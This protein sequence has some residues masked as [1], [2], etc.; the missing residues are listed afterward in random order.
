[1]Q[2]IGLF[3][4]TLGITYRKIFRGKDIINKRKIK[5]VK[6]TETNLFLGKIDVF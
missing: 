4:V 6:K 3:F 2:Y 1:M 5:L